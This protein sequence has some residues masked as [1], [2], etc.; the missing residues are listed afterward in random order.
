MPCLRGEGT[1]IIRRESGSARLRSGRAVRGSVLPLDD[2]RRAMCRGGRDGGVVV[3]GDDVAV[4]RK[5]RSGGYLAFSWAEG[6]RRG[7]HAG[8]LSWGKHMDGR[9]PAWTS[10]NPAVAARVKKLVKP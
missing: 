3:L 1:R 8:C 5:R 2:R 6:R 4:G 7:W 10:S 9:L